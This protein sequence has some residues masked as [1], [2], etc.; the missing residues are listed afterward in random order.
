MLLLLETGLTFVVPLVVVVVMRLLLRI[1]GM[2]Q[3]ASCGGC[4]GLVVQTDRGGGS[5]HVMHV[6]ANFL[7][8]RGK[9]RE[10]EKTTEAVLVGCSCCGCCIFFHS[11]IFWLK[12][13]EQNTRFKLK[14]AAPP[15]RF[16]PFEG[17]DKGRLHRVTGIK[18]GTVGRRTE[19][20]GSTARDNRNSRGKS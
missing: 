1:A 3:G 10:V 19:D 18:S 7:E 15:P 16:L 2:V 6:Y 4:S 20:P 9:K 14:S 17:K 12:A 5:V 8:E 13:R 11:H